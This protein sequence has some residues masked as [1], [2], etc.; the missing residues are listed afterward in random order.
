MTDA[1]DQDF[2]RNEPELVPP[3]WRCLRC[4]SSRYDQRGA[5]LWVCA[6]CGFDQFY[7]SRAPTRQ[8][9]D[10]GVWIYVPHGRGGAPSTSSESSTTTSASNAVRFSGPTSPTRRAPP[11][12]P[13]GDGWAGER[14]ESM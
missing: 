6:L 7:D 13:P 10:R 9:G 2:G 1:D 4:D 8:E 11:G 14:A 12:S 5:S 3:E